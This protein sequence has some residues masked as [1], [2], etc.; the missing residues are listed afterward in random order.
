MYLFGSRG[1]TVVLYALAVMFVLGLGFVMFRMMFGRGLSR[2]DVISW[3]SVT[4]AVMVFEFLYSELDFWRHH[5]GMAGVWIYLGM[6][7][8]AGILWLIFAAFSG[9]RR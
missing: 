1:I 2:R 6:P 3:V 4:G 7:F 5:N 8:L 9:R